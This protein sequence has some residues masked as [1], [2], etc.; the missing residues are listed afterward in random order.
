MDTI[1]ILTIADHL[2][3]KQKTEDVVIREKL[4]KLIRGVRALI[5]LCDVGHEVA[6][7]MGLDIISPKIDEV[8]LLIGVEREST[9]N[10]VVDVIEDED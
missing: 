6:A 8:V 5:H 9:R 4:D 2:L 1:Q 7:K 10:L 3:S